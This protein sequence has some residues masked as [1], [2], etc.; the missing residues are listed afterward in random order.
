[1]AG[2][3]DDAEDAHSGRPSFTRYLKRS[4]EKAA[5]K[6]DLKFV[7]SG[8]QPQPPA[9]SEDVV[10][11][12][13]AA[14][15]SKAQARRAQVRKAQ[16]QHRQRKAN[17]TKEL[18]MDVTRLRDRIQQAEQENMQF[19]RQNEAMRNLLA[20]HNSSN[21]VSYSLPPTGTLAPSY[22][23]SLEMSDFM[24]K[25][26]FQVKRAPIA[27]APSGPIPTTTAYEANTSPSAASGDTITGP[28]ATTATGT[29]MP[30]A[31]SE[32]QADRVINFIL[33]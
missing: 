30:F 1:M 25:P 13:N 23:V 16:I 15:Q 14:G 28:G 5:G 21:S 4:K 22:D 10:E 17:Y 33:A 11:G 24:Y 9:A 31:L 2:Q 6:K 19:R 8:Q 18:E 20:R 32:E 7:P 27:S 29:G 3:F 26:M 12:G